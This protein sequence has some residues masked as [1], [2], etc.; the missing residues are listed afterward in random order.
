MP[1]PRTA[2]HG[3]GGRGQTIEVDPNL[4]ESKTIIFPI[5]FEGTRCEMH[6]CEQFEINFETGEWRK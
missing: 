1:L 3:T 2:V 6:Y 4:P 5:T